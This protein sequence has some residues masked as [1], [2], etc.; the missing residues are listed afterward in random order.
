[1]ERAPAPRA[2]FTAFKAHGLGNDY[3]V[4]DEDDHWSLTPETVSRVCHR[5]RGA[6]SD[7]IVWVGRGGPPFRMRGFNPDGS[8]FER[9]GNGL[10]V[11]GAWLHR[12]GRVGDDPFQVQVGGDTVEMQILE[13]DGDRYDIVVDMGA[14]TARPEERFP[15]PGVGAGDLSL[16]RASVGNPHAVVW[17]DPDPWSDGRDA[18]LFHA[19]G[20]GL[21]GHPAFPEGTN[22]QLARVLS[23]DTLRALVWERGVGP[24][25]ASGTS[26]CAVAATAVAT[27]RVPAGELTVRMEGGDFQ[28]RVDGRLNVCLRGPVEVTWEGVL[29]PGI[30]R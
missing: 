16:V 27:G 17:G 14:C 8:E 5:T 15:L 12:A 10:R 21:T 29:A 19:V 13:A 22:V 30:L 7:G 2:G 4:V 25:E 1:M 20:S 18:E 26:A 6:G 28:V 9:S 24:T 11:L 23:P 3:L